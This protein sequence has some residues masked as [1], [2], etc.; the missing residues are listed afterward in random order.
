MSYLEAILCTQS[1]TNF[2][3]VW[4]IKKKHFI[5]VLLKRLCQIVMD[6]GL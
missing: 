6:S 4:D 1:T 2:P 5:N 3:I